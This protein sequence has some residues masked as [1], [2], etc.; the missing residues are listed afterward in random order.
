[1]KQLILTLVMAG[2]FVLLGCGEPSEDAS[3]SVLSQTG[4]AITITDIPAD[5]TC[6]RIRVTDSDNVSRTKSADV[7]GTDADAYGSDVEIEFRNLPV[8]P[9]HLELKAF[10]E[11]CDD[12]EPGTQP[13]WIGEADAEVISG[14]ITD[15]TISAENVGGLSV[16]VEWGYSVILEDDFEDGNVEPWVI[17]TD[18]VSIENGQLKLLRTPPH[19]AVAY[20]DMDVSFAWSIEADITMITSQSAVA[21][22]LFYV[23]EETRAYCMVLNNETQNSSTPGLHLIRDS[24]HDNSDTPPEN[25]LITCSF[26]PVAGE[27]HHVK[28]VRNASGLFTLYLDGNECGT[29]SD[30]EITSFNRI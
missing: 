12:V 25:V 13:S 4:L 22:C 16:G 23:E 9:A 24:Y 11:A 6:I 28:T 27:L 18:G 3:S 1:M 2:L 7:E 21:F 30:S 14:Q 19:H 5:V 26:I 29:V 10:R 8:G 20:I 15:V 17:E